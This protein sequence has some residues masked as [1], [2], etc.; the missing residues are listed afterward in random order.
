MAGIDY[1]PQRVAVDLAQ[2]QV[3]RVFLA[4][5]TDEADVQPFF[6]QGFELVGGE[7]FAQRQLHLRIVAAVV[8]DQP[9]NLG[10]ALRRDLIARQYNI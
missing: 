4:V 9:S 5:E 1:Q 7:H 3:R 6:A 2:Q 10:T 8:G